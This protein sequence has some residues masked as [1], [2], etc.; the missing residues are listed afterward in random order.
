MKEKTIA[1]LLQGKTLADMNALRREV[2][3]RTDEFLSVGNYLQALTY[4][5]KQR[6]ISAIIAAEIERR[7]EMLKQQQEAE[8]AILFDKRALK[9]K[10]ENDA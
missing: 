1:A 3:A 4:A 7:L 2:T 5:R 6:E 9:G 8:D 10:D